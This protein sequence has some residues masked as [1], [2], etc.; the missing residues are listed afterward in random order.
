MDPVMTMSRRKA[1]GALGGLSALGLASGAF[2]Q[3]GNN[4]ESTQQ[5]LG[6]DETKGEYTLPDLPYGYAALEPAIDEQ[7][8]RIHHTKHH[9]GYVRGLNRA[10]GELAKI[11]SGSG[12]A[13]LI[14]HWSR[15]LSFHGGG[16]LNHTLF[17]QG[18][19]P[20]SQ[21]GGGIPEGRIA[22]LIDRDFGSFDGFWT[23][24]S[25]AAKAVEASGWA[26]LVY[27]PVGNRLMVNQMEKQ[28]DMLVTGCVPLVGIDVWEHAYYLKYQNK[29][30]DYVEAFKSVINWQRADRLLRQA[31]GS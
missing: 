29:R 6:W 14:K 26:W 30:A 1:I 9:A 27:E 10:L 23:H 16:H 8:M 2:A 28:Q 31:M 22:R 4:T 5:T 24:F 18:M 20:A 3:D 21:G 11:R 12:D 25:A 15:E 7:T 17:W 13:G 19:K